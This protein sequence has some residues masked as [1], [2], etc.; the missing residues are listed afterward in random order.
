MEKQE[1]AEM[2]ND[3]D[4]GSGKV[5]INLEWGAFGDDGAIDFVRCEYDED[6]DKNSINPGKQK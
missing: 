2:W 4:M 5:S 1:N 6:V 3:V